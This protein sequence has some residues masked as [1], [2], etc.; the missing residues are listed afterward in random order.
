MTSG[1]WDNMK[2]YRPLLWVKNSSPLCAYDCLI[3]WG[4]WNSPA[5]EG[6]PS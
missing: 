5:R 2:D 6:V 3:L 4:K 1:R